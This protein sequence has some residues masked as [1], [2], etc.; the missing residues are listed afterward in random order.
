MTAASLTFAINTRAESD[1]HAKC[2]GV[3]LAS[4]LPALFWAAL[5]SGIAPM[6]GFVVT[7][8]QM[9]VTGA[10]I[11]SFLAVITAPLMLR[12]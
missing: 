11:A 1:G 5:I 9:V 3:L 4:V 12:A 10:A 7:A 2:I 8:G 6:F